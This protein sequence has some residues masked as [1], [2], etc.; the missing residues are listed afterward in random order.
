MRWQFTTLTLSSW[1]SVK[2]KGP[3]GQEV[4]LGVKHT[5]T[6]GGKC[7]G[8]ILMT[9][10]CIFTLELHLCRICECLEP[11]LERQ[12]STKLGPQDNIKKFLKLRCLKCPYN[13]QLN[14]I[15]MSYDQK[16]GWGQMKSNWGVLYIIKRLF[17]GL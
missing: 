4:C 11:W 16:K 3:W 1:L 7:K 8:W 6:N 2:C 10:K 12:T 13:V 17:W 5:F 9:P 15:C 14:L